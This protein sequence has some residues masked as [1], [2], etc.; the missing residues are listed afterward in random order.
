MKAIIVLAAVLIFGHTAMAQG[1]PTLTSKTTPISTSY[2]YIQIQGK[3]LSKKLKVEVDLGDS[4]AQIKA[5][6]EISETLTN[7][8]SYAAILNYMVESGYELV[9]TLEYTSSYAGSGGTA[10]IVFIMRKVT[11]T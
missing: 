4:P 7:K 9:D 6:E 5:G 8:K 2:A 1:L 11:T 3:V 10:G